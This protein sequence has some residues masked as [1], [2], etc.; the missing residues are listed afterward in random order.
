VAVR[1]LQS[2]RQRATVDSEWVF[3]ATDG[4]HRKDVKDSWISVC[5]EAGIEGA[6]YH[7]LRHTYASV[8]V[9]AGLSLP[10]IGGLLGH[11]T[12]TTTARY[13]HLL[14]STLRK[15]AERATAIITGRQVRRRRG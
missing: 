10:I 7:D 14:D 8:L 6:R 15:A 3:P 9:S 11:T 2:I 12:T 1:L 4:S 13:A 5:R